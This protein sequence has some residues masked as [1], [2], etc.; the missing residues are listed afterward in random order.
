MREKLPGKGLIL[1]GSV[2]LVVVGLIMF[3]TT[4][5]QISSAQELLQNVPDSVRTPLQV[6]VYLDPLRGAF[7]IAAGVLGIICFLN[8]RKWVNRCAIV[9]IIMIV[10]E[11][12]GLVLIAY[13]MSKL[14]V[15]EG[16][17]YSLALLAALIQMTGLGRLKQKLTQESRSA[18]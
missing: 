14:G 15:N 5:V 8:P 10:L 18:V 4:V 1:V 3:C 16:F 9:C 7:G 17:D 13:A 2:L 6:S 12:V 11:F